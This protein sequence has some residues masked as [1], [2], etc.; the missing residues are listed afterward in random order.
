VERENPHLPLPPGNGWRYQRPLY[1]MQLNT[2]ESSG[3]F[4][5]IITR[6]HSEACDVIE[7]LSTAMVKKNSENSGVIEGINF[8]AC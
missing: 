1:C 5:V 7:Q 8:T 6:E 3:P 4:L 2:T